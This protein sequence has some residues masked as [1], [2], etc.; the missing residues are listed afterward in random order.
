[1]STCII[2]EKEETAN[3][4]GGKARRVYICCWWLHEDVKE[5]EDDTPVHA[6]R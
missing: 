5:I 6:R 4:N 3:K 1:M 2:C